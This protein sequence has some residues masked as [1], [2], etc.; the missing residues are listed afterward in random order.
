[1]LCKICGRVVAPPLQD[2]PGKVRQ[3]QTGSPDA[4]LYTPQDLTPEQQEQART[5]IG[6]T[7][8]EIFIATVNVSTEQD[9][10]TALEAGKA[11]F[12]SVSY[13]GF[14]RMLPYIGQS[15]NYIFF[16]GI[17]SSAT[18]IYSLKKS[19]NTWAFSQTSYENIENKTSD[20]PGN[21]EST[22]KYPSTKGVFD[23]LGK[24]G[25]VSQTQTWSGTGTN[26]RTYTMSEQVWGLIPQ[27]NIDLYVSA[28]AVFN[29]STGYFE[30][31]GLTDISYNEMLAIYNYSL[32]FLIIRISRDYSLYSGK[33]RL[34]RTL[35]PFPNTFNSTV[36][37]ISFAWAFFNT[38]LEVIPMNSFISS[39]S[40]A[41]R[42]SNYIRDLG[43]M[44]I[45]GLTTASGLS[46][47]FL[48]AYS[49]ESVE[50]KGLKY[51][52]DFAQSSA[53]SL[54]SVVYMVDNAAN[55]SAITITL[56]ATAFA[57][58]QADTT[59]YT[60]NGQTYTGIIAYAAARNITIASA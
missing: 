59:E 42:Q 11:V 35:L 54:A 33:G 15:S 10:N 12:C 43:K 3:I 1:M 16:G 22:A 34:L 2:F 60:Y 8:P 29:E 20:I 4:V 25:V 5:N 49:L 52:I 27:A 37:G 47:A 23:A 41:F 55:T 19:N 30:L 14:I 9:I 7:A 28:G 57:R 6:A 44:N 40:Q 26:P 58:C 45:G 17:Y 51:S 31:N 21:R 48:Y 18:W 50:I 36:G 39:L 56:H 53:L 32:D 38:L 13:S 24:W 46:N